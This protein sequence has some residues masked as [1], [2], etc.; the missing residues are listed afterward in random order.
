MNPGWFLY[1]WEIGL[2]G[3][4]A[5]RRIGSRSSHRR[6]SIKK[7]VLKNLAVFTRTLVLM[8]HVNKVAGVARHLFSCEKFLRTP[9]LKNNC[10]RLLIWTQNNIF[11]LLC[12]P[13]PP[14]KKM[15][16]KNTKKTSRKTSRMKQSISKIFY[17]NIEYSYKER[18]SK[19]ATV[20]WLWVVVLSHTQTCR[21]LSG[22]W[23]LF[24]RSG[25]GIAASKIFKKYFRVTD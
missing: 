22:G 20:D 16:K 15:E 21:N 4:S 18:W 7:A 11:I 14:K 12:N 8:F 25:G 23:L 10:E 24:G 6:C 5:R 3:L 9:I 17:R 19:S 1:E 2:S 13:P